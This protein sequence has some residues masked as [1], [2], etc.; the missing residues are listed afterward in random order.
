MH[1]VYLVLFMLLLVGASNVLVRIVRLPLPLLQIAFGAA[2]AIAPRVNI[3]I[4]LDPEIFLFLFIPPL[5]FSG[6]WRIPKREFFRDKGVI[7]MLAFGLVFFT[8]A[9]AGVFVHWLIPAIS[10]PAAFAL[11]A[12]LSP[13]DTVAVAAVSGKAAI[14]PRLGYILA[15]ESLLNDASG[16]VAFKFALAAALTGAFSLGRATADFVYISA[17]GL[18]AGVLLTLAADAGRHYFIRWRGPSPVA[19]MI[20]TLLLPFTAYA[21]ANAIGGSGILAAA[22]GGIALSLSP[23]A[24]DS[25]LE[26][27]I[28]NNTIWGLLEMI[29]NGSIFI[30]L[31]LQLPEILGHMRSNAAEAGVSSPWWLAARVLAITAAIFALRFLWVWLSLRLTLLRAAL[32]VRRTHRHENTPASQPHNAP[33]AP[34]HPA[35]P[36]HSEHS[37]HERRARRLMSARLIAATTLA[38]VRGAV[39]LAAILS[40][41]LLLPDAT[42]FPA[43]NLLVFLASGVIVLSLLAGTFGL[44]LVLRHL[45][46]PAD[47]RATL[48]EKD[49]RRLISAAALKSLVNDAKVSKALTRPPWAVAMADGEITPELKQDLR[50]RVAKIYRQRMDILSADKTVRTPAQCAYNAEFALRLMAMRASRAELYRLYESRK[51]NNQ[52]LDTLLNEVDMSEA[53][54]LGA[55]VGRW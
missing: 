40:V 3:H 7:L 19:H 33:G 30:L 31:G 45:K 16:L 22:G 10:L 54:L 41:P 29:F 28:Q 36:A 39:T 4:S 21:A 18:A 15:G 52:T 55:N 32:R 12:V 2:L 17:S 20:I 34:P 49:A 25:S 14:P 5:L 8:T 11:A 13:T 51:I 53:A 24:R 44:P 27:R 37:A 6:G 35:H 46:M 1:T 26:M 47:T 23:F 43:R 9:G 48:E 42:P 38:G 50:E